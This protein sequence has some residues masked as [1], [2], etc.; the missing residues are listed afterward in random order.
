MP[1]ADEGNPDGEN[2]EGRR[3]RGVLRRF[4]I[5]EGNDVGLDE[6]R[7]PAPMPADALILAGC[8]S[9]RLQG[10]RRGGKG[11]RKEAGGGGSDAP[12]SEEQS[13]AT[14]AR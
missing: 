8:T 1:R 6:G 12:S 11:E 9:R 14:R 4:E 3:V 13:P 5:E 2:D 10:E 7:A